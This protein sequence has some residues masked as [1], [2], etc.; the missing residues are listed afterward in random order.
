MGA[1]YDQ[2]N[3]S[4]LAC[5]F[6]VSVSR[7]SQLVEAQ[8]V[9]DHWSGVRFLQYSRSETQHCTELLEDLCSATCD[10]RVRARNRLGKFGGLS[11]FLVGACC[12][13]CADE[14]A[15]GD[16]SK[17]TTGERCARPADRVAE[18]ARCCA[19]RTVWAFGS[20]PS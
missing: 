17:A 12:F 18:H 15:H 9:E 20:C 14:S 7:L 6:E 1:C 13:F 11:T 2:I 8:S 16:A 4:N 19:G 10:R 5:F 3:A